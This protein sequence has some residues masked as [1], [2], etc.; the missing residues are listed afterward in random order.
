MAQPNFANL[1]PV[2]NPNGQ[3]VF[4]N[5]KLGALDN[6]PPVPLEQKLRDQP[7]FLG[8]KSYVGEVGAQQ[9]EGAKKIAGSVTQGA[10]NIN[11]GLAKGRTLEGFGQTMMGVGLG[12]L[13]T[14]TGVGQ[15]AAAPFTPAIQKVISMIPP[16][17]KG[18][19]VDKVIQT[20]G[21]KMDALVKA[22]PEGATLISDAFNT[23]LLAIGGGEVEAPLKGALTK[24]GL[25]AVKEDIAGATSKVVGKLAP[26]TDV[27]KALTNITPKTKDLTPT[28]YE[29]LLSKK[30]ITPKTATSPSQY[31]LS[32]EE[33]AVAT[34][35]KD[36]LQDKDPVKNSI[37]VMDEIANKDSQVG[38]FLDKNNKKIDP[39]SMKSY[40]TDKMKDITDITIDPTRLDKSK[41]QMINNF[42]DSLKEK[43]VKNAWIDRKA[44]DAKIE[45]AFKGSP[46]L[47]KDMKRGLRNAVQDYI[48]ENTPEGVYKGYMKDMTQL[49]NIQDTLANAASKEKGLNAL[50]TWIKDNPNKARILG[51]GGTAIVGDKI[52]KAT[53]GIG[54]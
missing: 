5:L 30:K 20:V 37:N 40:L 44:F 11:E 36:L 15:I 2:T 23:L 8:T 39:V 22:H 17:A 50:Q 31:I 38:D 4:A 48:A 9:V 25:G 47:I 7:G 1:K 27:E 18:S 14:I 16:P 41:Q 28:E 34:K 35:Y 12:A 21:P 42:V 49:F 29:N 53:T 19:V 3:P 43:D 24:E 33:K 45:T 13:G 10:K 46:S 51:W 26:A 6:N 32:D 54:F 52:L